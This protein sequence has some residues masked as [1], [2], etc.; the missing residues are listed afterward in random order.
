MSVID[1]QIDVLFTPTDSHGELRENVSKFAKLELDAQAKDND[2]NET[3]NKDVFKKL[4]LKLDF[5]V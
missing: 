4:V 3:F 2:E 1:K 5:S